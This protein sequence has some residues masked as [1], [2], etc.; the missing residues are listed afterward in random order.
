MIKVLLV[1]DEQFIRQG[2]RKLIDWNQYGYEIEA[3]A[4]NGEKAIEI[5]EN[6]IEIELVFVDIRMPGM[7]GIEF[8][9]YVQKNMFRTLQFVILTGYADFEYVRRAL[10]LQVVDYMLNRFGKKN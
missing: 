9:E 6:N 8:I 5:L 1:D 10:R 7:T 2:L 4:E 3:E